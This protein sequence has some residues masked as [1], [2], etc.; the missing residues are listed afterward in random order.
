MGLK[1][2]IDKYKKKYGTKILN[3]KYKKNI[4]SKFMTNKN[5]TQKQNLLLINIKRN[6]WN[7]DLIIDK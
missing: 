6:A 4:R 7:Q 2:V 3:N 5:N 1:F